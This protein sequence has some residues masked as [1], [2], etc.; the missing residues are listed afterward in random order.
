MSTAANILLKNEQLK[1]GT[2]KWY[3]L[4]SPFNST[5]EV[6][7]MYWNKTWH[8]TIR[9]KDEICFIDGSDHLC[10]KLAGFVKLIRIE[11]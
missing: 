5:R 6:L 3:L 10:V 9:K 11:L 1:Q 8:I 7:H 4:L 2:R